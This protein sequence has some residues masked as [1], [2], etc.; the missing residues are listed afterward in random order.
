[1]QVAEQELISAVKSEKALP[2]DANSDVRSEARELI[3]AAKRKLGLWDVAEQDIDAIASADE[4][5]KDVPFRSPATG[6]IEDKTIVQ[7]SA[8]QAMTKLMRVSDH[9]QMWLD[10]Q[11]YQEQI[12]V[13]KLGQEVIATVDGTSDVWK[14]KITFIH[15]HLDH[16]TRTLTVRVTLDNPDFALKPGMYATA[17]II[18][19]PIADAIQVPGEAVIDTGTRQIVFTAE[20]SGH[21]SPRTVSVGLSGDDDMVQI[22]RGLAAG[23]TVVTSGQ[24][25]MDVESRT[26][27]ATQKLAGSTGGQ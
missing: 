18:T 23:E 11:V 1:L 12:P 26:I 3:D 24:F 5:P 27:E 21:F 20:S 8:V 17:Q 6:H 15:P 19:Q 14:G 4:P 7:G 16:M 9:T 22:T 25:L 2:A 10:A 13:V